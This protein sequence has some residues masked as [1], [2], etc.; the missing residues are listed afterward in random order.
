M[1]DRPDAKYNKVLRR[2][3]RATQGCDPSARRRRKAEVSRRPSGRRDASPTKTTDA[4]GCRPSASIFPT[5]A[6]CPNALNPP[7]ND[8]KA[9]LSPVRFNI[10]TTQRRN[11]PLL[12]GSGET[13]PEYSRLS[14]IPG[15][16]VHTSP[17]RERG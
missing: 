5:S 12:Y 11:S 14:A 7:L 16:A 9:S 10:P 13:I 1:A 17:K 15:R 6:F 4:P 8:Q 3:D 2:E